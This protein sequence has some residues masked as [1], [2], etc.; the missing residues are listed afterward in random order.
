MDSAAPP[1]DLRKILAFTLPM[2][3]FLLLLG[4]TGFLRKEGGALWLASPE[5]WTYPAQTLVC[6]ALL[7][8]FWRDYPLYAARQVLVT[9]LVALA[10]FGLWIAPQAFLGFAPRLDGFNPEI[11][12]GQ[13][14]AYWTTVVFRFLRLVVVVPLVEEIFW[15]GFVLRYFIDEKF[16]AVPVGAFSWLS[17]AAV[18]LGFG[19]S[20]ARAD[21][22]PALI[23]GALYNCVAYRSKSLTSCV[24]AHAITNLLLGLWIMK[25][26]QWGFW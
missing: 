9:L 16:Y 4:F 5:Y 14:T 12:S 21:W 11:F 20:H 8:W 25:T 19:F 6:G 7:L 24:I 26:G 10:V 13:P 3:V 18:T 17:F 1:S 2:G 23:T 22:V 15:R